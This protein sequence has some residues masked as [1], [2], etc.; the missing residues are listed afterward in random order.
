MYIDCSHH[1][2]FCFFILTVAK[3]NYRSSTLTVLMIA[4]LDY[5]ILQQHILYFNRS[6]DCSSILTV[7]KNAVTGPVFLL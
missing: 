3:T 5:S 1:Y 2:R 4:A 6:Q 7:V